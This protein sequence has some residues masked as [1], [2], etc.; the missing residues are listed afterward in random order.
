[1]YLVSLAQHSAWLGAAE[2]P[3][4]PSYS[5]RTARP[6]PRYMPACGAENGASEGVSF[7]LGYR[8]GPGGLEALGEVLAPVAEVTLGGLLEHGVADN[9]QPG[10]GATWRRVLPGLRER[11]SQPAHPQQLDGRGAGFG[12]G[13][14]VAH[15]GSDHR[16]EGALDEARA[17]QEVEGGLKGE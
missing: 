3:E 13:V 10:P 5:K 11:D 7:L 8:S 6:Q 9:A 1:M 2:R 17:T 15:G 4:K 14:G 16:S 12:E